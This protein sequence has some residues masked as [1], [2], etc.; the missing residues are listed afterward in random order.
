MHCFFTCFL[1]LLFCLPGVTSADEARLARPQ[2][3]YADTTFGRGAFAKDPDVVRFRATYYMYYSARGPERLLA[4]G[5]AQSDDLT[6]W[7][8]VGHLLPEQECEKNGV[9]A[10]GAMVW[11][12]KVHLFYQSYGNR[13]NDAICHAT[14]EDGVTFVRDASN[15]VFAPKGDWTVGR[16]IDA[17]IIALE[18]QLLLY[19]ATRDPSFK[20]Q[21][22]GVASAPLESDFSRGT[23]TQRCNMAILKPELPWEKECIEAPSVV[24]HDGRLYMFYAGAYNNEPQQIG[25]AVSNDGIAWKRL[26]DRPL[27][28][29][30]NA[31]SWNACESG[32]PG[33]FVD[34]D[35]KMYLFFQGNNDRGKTWLLSK[36]EVRWEDRGPYLVRPGDGEEFHLKTIPNN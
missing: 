13:E 32:H 34:D 23:W 6:S 27:L 17:D 12:G 26:S 1:L 7:H 36:M 25:V 5:I 3:Y 9:A 11:Q 16:A 4:I 35:G 2:M 15:P 21:M 19:W 20:T 30:G 10:P 28:P 22:I 31:G 33:V 24:E 18:D 29:N 14:S 8:T